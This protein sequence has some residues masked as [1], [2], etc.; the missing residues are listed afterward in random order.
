MLSTH[1][2]VPCAPEADGCRT[3]PL[4]DDLDKDAAQSFPISE[5]RLYY[6]HSKKQAAL[7]EEDNPTAVGARYRW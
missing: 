5:N 3:D 2:G 6:S 1:S 7:N 4:A